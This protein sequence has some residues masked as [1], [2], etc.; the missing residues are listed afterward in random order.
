[1]P[2]EAARRA[3]ATVYDPAGKTK[4]V[5]DVLRLEITGLSEAISSNVL[6]SARGVEAGREGKRAYL[7]IPA[8]T[9]MQAG[10]ELIWDISWK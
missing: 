4:E 2:A 7:L 10:E 6:P 3:L 8:E 5:A 9:A 1:V